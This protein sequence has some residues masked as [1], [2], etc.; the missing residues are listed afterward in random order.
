MLTNLD[1]RENELG[2]EGGIAIAE[3]LKVNAVMKKCDLQCNDLGD[4]EK[5]MLRDAVS[6]RESFELL[7]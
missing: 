5:K 2:K 7:V 4:A 3:A 6:G 1:L